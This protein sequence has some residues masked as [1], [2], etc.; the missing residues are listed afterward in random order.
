MT[1]PA[2]RHR[3]DR[4]ARTYDDGRVVVG[5]TP[6]R[7]FRLT[8]AGARWLDG[9]VHGDRGASSP[10]TQELLD[11]LV[12]AGVVHPEPDAAPAPDRPPVSMVVPVRDRP[13]EL[14]ALLE[15]VARSGDRPD[16]IVVVDDGS[17][18]AAAHRAVC[19]THG[20]R[21]E[22]REVP[23]GPGAARDLGLRSANH[24]LVVFVD[25]D[26][27]VTPGWLAGLVGHLADDAVVAVAGRVRSAVVPGRLGEYER[28]ESPL[29]LGDD[30][31][32]V[33]PGR[34]IGHVPAALLLVRRD[35]HLAA[36]GFDDDLRVGEDV[37][38]VWRLVESGGVVRYE[39][40]VV[41]DHRPRPDL[42]SWCA[43]RFAYGT[44][45]A[46]LDLRHPDALT[47][48]RSS[49]WSLAV[50]AAVVLGHP[51]VAG[52]L[53]LATS[54][55]LVRRLPGIPPVDAVRVGLEGHLAALRAAGRAAARVW[56]P[57]VLLALVASRRT[58]RPALRLLLV[59]LADRW[60]RRGDPIPL[61]DLPL[62]VLDD[63]S[64][65]AGV[66]AGCLR[67]G[68]PGPLLPSVRS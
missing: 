52:V 62:A 21:L 67:S 31:G 58:R 12:V 37:D 1:A 26:V 51:L 13:E 19:A 30:P 57:V 54:V 35:A 48:W 55:P 38:L 68:R 5:G 36:G 40:A 56:W 65:G 46:P 63:L 45:A 66:W 32:P 17:V 14:A 11:R 9:L 16:E 60:W 27:T 25:S 20:A 34:R 47:P 28:L 4:T 42:G 22:R 43:Q 3:L 18:D 6:T 44:S 61:R 10:A 8:D 64:Y 41:V 49:P 24:E 59:G 53:A 15:S 2:V 23:G 39:P 29:D 33:G 7:M 50:V